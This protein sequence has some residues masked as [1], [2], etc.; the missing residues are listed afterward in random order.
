[1]SIIGSCVS[2][3]AFDVKAGP[4]LPN[5]K[6][7]AA[8]TSFGSAF[9]KERFPLSLSEIDPNGTIASQWQRRMIERDFDKTLICALEQFQRHDTV[10]LD[11]IDER[12]DLLCYRGYIATYSA[13]LRK[14]TNMHNTLDGVRLIQSG[15]HEHVERWIEGFCRFATIADKLSLR[16]VLNNCRWAEYTDTGE[17]VAPEEYVVRSNSFL[18]NLYDIARNTCDLRTIYDDDHE[19]VASSKHKWST[20]PFHY[21]EDS[22]IVFK[23]RLVSILE[24]RQ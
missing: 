2:R 23:E 11:F 20:A 24:S 15:S 13:E 9:V 18:R 1:M 7:Y 14:N 12:F 8:R 16:L 3:D 17:R 10:I 21:T 4:Q 19:F 5:V 22:Y 6:F